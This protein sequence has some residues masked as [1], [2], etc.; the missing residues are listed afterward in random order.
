MLRRYCTIARLARVTISASTTINSMIVKPRLP[1]LVLRP[2]KR[3]PVRRRVDVEHILPTPGG[4]VGVVLVRPQ[5]PFGGLDH[6]I[7]RYVSQ[8]PDLAAS[9]VVR[10]RDTFDQRLQRFRVPFAAGLDLER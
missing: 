10:G 8:E 3:C 6:R 7:D 5:A 2:I 1:V 4:R 9:D